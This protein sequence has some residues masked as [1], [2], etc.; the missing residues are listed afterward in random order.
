[1]S[2]ICWCIIL[3]LPAG[4]MTRRWGLR[5]AP[6]GDDAFHPKGC[7]RFPD[8]WATGEE[9]NSFV[10]R[11]HWYF[12]RA[13]QRPDWMRCVPSFG[14]PKV[15]AMSRVSRFYLSMD[16]DEVSH[17]TMCPTVQCPSCWCPH[18]QLDDTDEVY[19]DTES[20]RNDATGSPCR[21]ANS[22]LVVSYNHGIFHTE[23]QNM[24]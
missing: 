20:E 17:A 9:A 22:R 6:A 3:Q 15:S 7:Y 12:S 16:K 5:P 10:P 23:T 1:M 21:A 2:D 18:D 11:V 19:K 4:S 8:G 14:R 13:N 24:L